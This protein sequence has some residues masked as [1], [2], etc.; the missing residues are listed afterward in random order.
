[1]PV[2]NTSDWS[3]SVVGAL[4]V[5]EGMFDSI[6]KGTLYSKDITVYNDYTYTYRA[7]I[8]EKLISKFPNL[9]HGIR[10]MKDSNIPI[11]ANYA[12]QK[13]Y[14]VENYVSFM[15][16]ETALQMSEK[17]RNPTSSA[18]GLCQLMDYSAKSDGIS[19]H[20]FRNMSASQQLN[21]CEVYLKK[22]DPKNKRFSDLGVLYTIIAAPKYKYSSDDTV[23]YRKGTLA[24]H[25]N[26]VW[27]V[28]D[29]NGVRDGV[30]KKGEF[31]KAAEVY[32]PLA[33]LIL[34]HFKKG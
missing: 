34:D 4:E 12:K 8:K 7:G 31:K 10:K 26:K 11:I 3:L 30:I 19:I 5:I 16:L 13:G 25:Y 28:K 32:R 29:R 33:R 18:S 24:Y 21:Q 15:L 27:D 9:K 14:D 6:D 1:M 2:A 20:A 22:R 23:V 17:T